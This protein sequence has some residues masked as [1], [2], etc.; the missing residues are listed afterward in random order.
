MEITLESLTHEWIKKTTHW[1]ITESQKREENPAIRDVDG[2]WGHYAK[3]NRSE[4]ERQIL[5]DL[6]DRWNLKTAKHID[7]VNRKVVTR[8][9]S[10]GKREMLA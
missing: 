3:W 7:T 8:D 10:K 4:K 9:W 6:T 5:C 1:T 2:P